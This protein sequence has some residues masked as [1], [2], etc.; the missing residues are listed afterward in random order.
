[1]FAQV[2]TRPRKNVSMN[3]RGCAQRQL[4]VTCVAHHE[5]CLVVSSFARRLRALRG[6]CG[7]PLVI[8]DNKSINIALQHGIDIARFHAAS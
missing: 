2:W 5:L 6:A 4:F 7:I 3:A 8:A 1:M